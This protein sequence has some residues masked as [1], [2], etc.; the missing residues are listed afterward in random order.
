[1]NTETI[2][3]G[4]RAVLKTNNINQLRGFLGDGFNVQQANGLIDFNAVK[5]LKPSLY[6]VIDV[7]LA[8]ARTNEKFEFVGTFLGV[9]QMTAGAGINIAFNGQLNKTLPFTSGAGRLY[10]QNSNHDRR[11]VYAVFQDFSSRADGYH[12]K[13]YR[14]PG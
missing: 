10:L 6:N 11:P 2:G 4:V 13:N 14:S 3:R 5:E 7:D 1:M 12:L 8:T 9:T